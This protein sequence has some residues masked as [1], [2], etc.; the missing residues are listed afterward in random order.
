MLEIVQ[1]QSGMKTRRGIVYV[2]PPDP[3]LVFEDGLIALREPKSLKEIRPSADLLLGSVADSFRSRVIAVVLS[4]MLSDGAVIDCLL[5]RNARCRHRI[6]L[7]ELC[8]ASRSHRRCRHHALYGARRNGSFPV[9]ETNLVTA[10]TR[11]WF[12]QLAWSV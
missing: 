11:H 6:R 7:H 9:I 4:G 12:G 5:S 3:H 8:S 1:T 2:A 10:I